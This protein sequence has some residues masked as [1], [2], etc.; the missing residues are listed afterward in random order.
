MQVLENGLAG[1]RA[2]V[3][4]HECPYPAPE[5]CLSTG[6]GGD[7]ADPP[8]QARPPTHPKPKEFSSGGN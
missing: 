7:L 6:G 8:P 4:H 3:Q 1:P 5:M 2:N